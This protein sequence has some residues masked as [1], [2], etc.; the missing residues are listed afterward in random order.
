MNAQDQKLMF[1]DKKE[2]AQKK[3]IFFL[4][5]YNNFVYSLTGDD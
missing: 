2:R 1:V 4:A 3:N 5:C